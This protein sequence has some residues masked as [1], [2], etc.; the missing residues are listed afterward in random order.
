M[1]YTRARPP[2]APVA[3]PQAFPSPNSDSERP[4]HPF[5]PQQQQQ[6]PHAQPVAHCNIFTHI[7]TELRVR[8]DSAL[9]NNPHESRRRIVFAQTAQLNEELSQFIHNW[10]N[11]RLASFGESLKRHPDDD[12]DDLFAELTP[13]K[14]PHRLN[15]EEEE[16]GESGKPNQGW[17]CLYYEHNPR[18]YPQCRDRKYKRVSEL[19]RHIKT[20]T[21]PHHC[22]KC[23]YRTAEER[24]LHSHK[25]EKANSKRY[26]PVTAEDKLKHEQLARMAVKVGQMKVILFGPDANNDA[27]DS[28]SDGNSYREFYSSPSICSF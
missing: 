2:N 15:E 27:A 21:L 24:R 25:C 4:L 5:P 8:T 14:R 1:A 3:A 28:T 23:G 18:L 19:R 6:I 17:L 10:Q 12:E 26:Q 9:H 11:S 20:H 13:K 22:E 16:D 7:D